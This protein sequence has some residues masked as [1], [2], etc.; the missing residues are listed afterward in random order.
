MADPVSGAAG[1]GAR[2]DDAAVEARLARLDALLAQLEQIPGRTAELALEVVETL[3]EV[4]GEALARTLDSAAGTP[5][6]LVAMTGDELLRH[7]FV[8]HGIH[9]APVEQRIAGALEDL[10]AHGVEAHLA[11]VRDGIAHLTTSAGSSCGCGSSTADD[12]V[13]DHVLAMAPELGGVELIPAEPAPTLIPVS[14]LRR[15]PTAATPG[16]GS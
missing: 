3:T 8:L 11:G 5:A 9:P 16:F 14:A 4:Y 12:V 7:L 15:R 2:L 13:R 6:T 1:A 10:R